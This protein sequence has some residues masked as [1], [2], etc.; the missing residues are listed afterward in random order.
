VAVKKLCS[1]GP[2]IEAAKFILKN[3][4][5]IVEKCFDNRWRHGIGQE[6]TNGEASPIKL[7]GRNCNF[8]PSLTSALKP[9]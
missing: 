2:T 3:K 1:K 4:G 5:A 9:I 7:Y 8:W 6:T